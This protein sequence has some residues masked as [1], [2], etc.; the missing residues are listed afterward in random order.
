VSLTIQMSLPQ[1]PKLRNLRFGQSQSLRN[2]RPY[3]FISKAALACWHPFSCITFDNSMKANLTSLVFTIAL[4][5]ASYSS[6]G[7]GA[8]TPPGAPAPTMKALDQI[9]PRTP[10]SS[11][12]LV[13]STSGS[14]YLVGSLTGNAGTNGIT[15][16][17]DNV[18]IDLNGFALIGKPGSSNGIATIGIIRNFC[19]RN[20]TVKAWG[21]SGVAA[22]SSWSGVFED[23]RADSNSGIGIE[24]GNGA[25]IKK[26]V[27]ISNTGVG[28]SGGNSSTIS[29]CTAMSN[30]GAGINGYYGSTIVGCASQSNTGVGILASSGNSIKNCSAMSNGGGGISTAGTCN[31]VGCAVYSNTGI[32]IA[33]GYSVVQDCTVNLNTA[34]GIY[35]SQN[36]TV[37]NNTLYQNGGF[38]GTASNIR[39]SGS[40]NRI[41]GNHV[42]LGNTGIRVDNIG[43][44]I[45]KNSCGGNSTN[46]NVAVN[47]LLGPMLSSSAALSTNSNPHANYDF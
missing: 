22:G 4:L 39:V 46:Y 25:V 32:G 29:D 21:R 10:I 18:T 3:R 42:I 41:E 11:L 43:N 40:Y 20:G 16:T 14:Y 28:I 24:T 31:I 45:I 26:C 15:V 19:V 8:L 9:E 5:S 17:A 23:L 33:T 30:G 13:I 6:H 27:S 47:N 12:P 35:V 44:L 2:K 38:G 34:E 36:A 1:S 7:Q 37:L